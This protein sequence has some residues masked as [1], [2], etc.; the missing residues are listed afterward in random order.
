[1][2]FVAQEIGRIRRAQATPFRS[3]FKIGPKQPYALKD[4]EIAMVKHVSSP[5][6]GG[7]MILDK[8]GNGTEKLKA[9]LPADLHPHYDKLRV[10]PRFDRFALFSKGQGR[11][12]VLDGMVVG[13]AN[14]DFYYVVA[15]WDINGHDIWEPNPGDARTPLIVWD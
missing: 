9:A 2:N 7:T 4:D 10:D 13:F 14:D 5:S 6:K 15:I 11:D 3:A 1:M 12:L 8:Q